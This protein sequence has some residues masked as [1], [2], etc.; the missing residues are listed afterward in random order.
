MFS[1]FSSGYIIVTVCIQSFSKRDKHFNV[2]FPRDELLGSSRNKNSDLMWC[3]NSLNGLWDTFLFLCL[4]HM[5]R[6][7]IS[8]ALSHATSSCMLS[9]HWSRSKDQSPIDWNLY[10]W[11]FTVLKSL[12]IYFVV[13]M[14][15]ILFFMDTSPFISLLLWKAAEIWQILCIYCVITCFCIPIRFCGP[16]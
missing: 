15:D 16:P 3:M 2:L 8:R 7:L 9:H 4:S 5:G 10:K 13:E 6:R 1:A 12:P 11:T 14:G